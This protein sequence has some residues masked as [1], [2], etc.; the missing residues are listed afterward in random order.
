MNTDN[1]RPYVSEEPLEKLKEMMRTSLELFPFQRASLFTYSPLTQE[2]Q[3]LLAATPCGI[4]SMEHIKEDVRSIPLV[5]MA[6]KQKKAQFAVISR[7]TFLF[8]EKYIEAFSLSSL[9][10][11]PLCDQHAVTGCVLADRFSRDQ[12]ID[13][14]LIGK[15]ERY[16]N[17]E[18]KKMIGRE[19]PVC[20]LSRREREI[21]Y[22][23]S[24]GLGTKEVADRIRISEY[25]VRDYTKSCMR[26]LG[27]KN[28]TEAV[29]I[30]LRERMID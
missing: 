21:L 16:F 12:A 11:V 28:R 2:A 14:V 5:E 1:M 26:K 25:T 4:F 15:V 7:S 29:A 10:V 20:K 19:E 22:W 18:V 24:R 9:L 3:G 17:H 27:A 23:F 6:I 30:A 8:P 13:D